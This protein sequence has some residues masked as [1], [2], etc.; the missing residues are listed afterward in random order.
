MSC[1]YSTNL[2]I[3]CYSKK[4]FPSRS[5]RKSNKFF[6]QTTNTF[7]ELNLIAFTFF[8]DHLQIFSFHFLIPIFP[9]RSLAP[10]HPPTGPN[11]PTPPF[12]KG[13]KEGNISTFTLLCILRFSL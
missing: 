6:F 5:V 3:I 12:S 13:G 4:Y 2:A 11:P 10:P 8:K 9:E 1:L 7:F